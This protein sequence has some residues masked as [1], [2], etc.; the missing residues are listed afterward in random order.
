MTNTYAFQVSWFNEF[1]DKSDTS[2]GVIGATSYKDAVEL[3]EKRYRNI[4]TLIV[5]YLFEYDGFFFLEKE[6]YEKVIQE[7]EDL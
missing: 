2:Y 4:S 3:I 7:N 5:T 6:E 1:E